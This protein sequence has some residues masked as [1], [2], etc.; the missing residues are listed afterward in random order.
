M[1]VYVNK[2]NQKNKKKEEKKKEEDPKLLDMGEDVDDDNLEIEGLDDG[3]D[4][5]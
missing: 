2:R 1:G 4:F 5:L 3:E